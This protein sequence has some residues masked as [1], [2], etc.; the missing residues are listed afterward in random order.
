MLLQQII[1]QTE[2][3]NYEQQKK[4]AS[5]FVLKYL[6]ADAN[7]LHLFY[8]TEF[9]MEEKKDNIL[10]FHEIINNYNSIDEPELNINTILDDRK[11]KNTRKFIFD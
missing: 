2:T 4:L 5:Y 6:N 3:L 1:K 10:N 7:L 9:D 11:Q 8:N